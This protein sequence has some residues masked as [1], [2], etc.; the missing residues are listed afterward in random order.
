M[1]NECNDISDNIDISNI[2]DEVAALT[3]LSLSNSGEW[4]GKMDQGV[5][6]LPLQARWVESDPRSHSRG[7]ELAPKLDSGGA[8]L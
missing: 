2:N 7:Q 4:V 6:V 3:T 5:K 8:H 1:V